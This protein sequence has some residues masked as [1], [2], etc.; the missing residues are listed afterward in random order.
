MPGFEGGG[1]DAFVSQNLRHNILALGGDFA[2]FMVGLSLASQSTIL[3]AFAAHLGASNVVIGAIPAVMTVGW[4][5]PSLFAAGHTEAL[6][7][8]LPF[9]LRYTIWERAPF[10]VLALA[11][12]APADFAPGLTLAVLLTMLLVIT[13]V[14]GILMPAWMDIVG[15]AIPINLRGRFFAV[16]N[17]VGSAGGFVG[18][19]ATAYIL[20]A[21]PAPVGYGVCFL[22]AAVFMGLSYV[23]LAFTREAAGGAA[24]P[25]LPLR[26]YLSRLPALLRRNRNFSWFLTARVFGALGMMASGFYTVY[27]LWTY[28]VPTSQVGVFTAVLFSGQI[29]GNVVFGWLADRA[30]HRLVIIAGVA[31]TVAANA[32]ALAARSPEAFRIVFA[33]SGVQVA[34]INVSSLNMLLEFAPVPAEQPTYVGLG[35]TSVAPTTFVAP[36]MAGVMA[37]ALGFESVFLTAVL[38]G[39]IALAL[40]LGL[41][42]DPRH[43]RAMA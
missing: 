19:F 28:A 15:R 3:P 20:A 5:F 30:G 42:R 41:V 8:K 4:L 35:N 24:S 39:V 11:A 25:A 12:F 40:L 37:D 18:G 17:L 43:E 38:F 6:A 32:L 7:R 36:L 1:R 26:A 9:V 34:A 21:F 14:G 16:A 10:L 13:G 2:L 27:A 23:A 22:L 29:A 33:L 31:A